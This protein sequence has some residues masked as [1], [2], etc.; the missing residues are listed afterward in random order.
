MTPRTQGGFWILLFV[1]GLVVC[2]ILLLFEAA[3]PLRFFIRVGVFA[4][5]LSYLSF[6]LLS[7]PKSKP[8]PALT[9]ALAVLAILALSFFYPKP[10]STASGIAHALLYLAILAPLFWV[11]SLGVDL[12]VLRMLVFVLWGFHTLSSIFGVLQVFFPGSFQS[13]ISAVL[14]SQGED[15]VQSLRFALASGQE[16]FRPM[17]LTDTP[18]GAA[19]S[20]LHA[21]IFGFGLML[22]ARNPL[23][24]FLCVAGMLIGMACIA[25]SQV[26]VML[27]LAVIFL[28]ALSF[29]TL[30]LIFARRIRLGTFLKVLF[31]ATLIS[32]GALTWAI[33]VGGESVKSRLSTLIEEKPTSVY[34][35]ERGYFLEETV[36]EYLPKYPLGAGLGRWGMM[37]RYF[38]AEDPLWA[39]IQITGWLF[40][41]G[42]PLVVV[43]LSMLLLAMLVSLRIARSRGFPGASELRIWGSLIFAYDVGILAATFVAPVFIGQGGL[44]FWL[45][46]ASLHSAYRLQIA[47]FAP[48]QRFPP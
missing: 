12:A 16:V 18:G 39:E 8:H 34:Y 45:F 42:I 7:R 13:Q 40:D 22:T 6:T 2:Q 21:I 3:Q 28:A 46:N 27:V 41:G 43:Y 10:E 17:G 23:F 25:F 5:S 48:A 47:S 11:P 15:Y 32:V 44:E 19:A 29:L 35:K 36:K 26:R 9:L 30:A 33:R 14:E 20:G 38:G 31:I 37:A 4:A 24:R 1:L